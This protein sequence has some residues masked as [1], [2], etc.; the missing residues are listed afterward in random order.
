M[1]PPQSPRREVCRQEEELVGQRERTWVWLGDE[2]GG[3]VCM[4]GEGRPGDTEV[5][6]YEVGGVTCGEL[7]N[8]KLLLT[9]KARYY[10]L[11][12]VIIIIIIVFYLLL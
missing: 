2:Q 6:Q 9:T 11:S 10:C 12:S 7:C 1:L 3:E 8:C 5:F 4:Q